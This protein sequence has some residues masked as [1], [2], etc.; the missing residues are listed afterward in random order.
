MKTRMP[1]TIV[2][3]SI[4]D[5]SAGK[6]GPGSEVA[7]SRTRE[8]AIKRLSSLLNG[9]LMKGPSNVARVIDRDG[10]DHSEWYFMGPRVVRFGREVTR[11]LCVRLH[12]GDPLEVVE[13]LDVR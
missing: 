9:C 1:Y 5:P 8:G 2:L 10:N 6:V 13:T 12:D 7:G 11:D 4:V 3:H